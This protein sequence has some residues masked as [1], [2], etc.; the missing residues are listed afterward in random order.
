MSQEKLLSWKELPK[1]GFVKEAGNSKL[2]HTGGWNAKHISFDLKD[3]IHCGICWSVCPDSAILF[4]DGQMQ[5]V[6]DEHCKKCELCQV[7]CPKNCFQITQKA[8]AEI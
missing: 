3:C 8:R 4:K 7:S 5:G 6:R 1:G 2:Y